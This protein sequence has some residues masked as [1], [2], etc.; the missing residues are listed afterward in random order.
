[1]LHAAAAAEHAP[2]APEPVGQVRDAV[3]FDLA[4]KRA[5]WVCSDLGLLNL[6]AVLVVLYVDLCAC[7]RSL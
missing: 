3:F 2:S 6:V 5:T 4:F 1:M 7:G